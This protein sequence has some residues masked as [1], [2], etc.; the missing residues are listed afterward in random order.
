MSDE[1][2]E[3]D[4][5]NVS[6]VRLPAHPGSPRQRAVKWLCLIDRLFFDVSDSIYLDYHWTESNLEQS[7]QLSSRLGRT[8][9]VYVGVDVFGRYSRGGGF[10]TVEVE[11]SNKL[12]SLSLNCFAMAP[13]G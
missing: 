2:H 1:G 5:V 11:F 12:L 3:C 4:W 9:N 13:M 7:E 6:S 8:H 10:N